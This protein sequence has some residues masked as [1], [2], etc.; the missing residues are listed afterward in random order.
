[1]AVNDWVG[2][3]FLWTG[4]DFL[5]EANRWPSHGSGAGLLDIEGFWKRDAYLRQALWSDK[6]MVHAAAWTTGDETR[7]G[8][9]RV[10]GR[11]PAV[12][13]WGWENDPRKNIP[14]E[15]YSNCDTVEVLLNGRSLG[16]KPI[17]DKLAPVIGWAVPNEAG[18]VEVVGR[19]AGAAAAR[20]QLRSVGKAEKILLKPDLVTLKDEARQVSTIEITIA[21]RDGR[22]VPEAADTITC[23]VTGA[24]K[25]V[26][27]GNAD[28]SDNSAPQGSSKKAYQGRA[29]A[30]VRSGTHA[31]KVTVKVSA[32]GLTPAE[33]TLT[34]AR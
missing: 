21:D 16:E 2:G 18:V 33:I 3:Q 34:V 7:I 30:I 23:E 31:G 8:D 26:A 32:P 28:L 11:T 24:G 9:Q 22:R 6:P 14:V 13:R 4:M 12:E 10:L 27:V 19:K 20:F 17:A 1:V 29:V 25:L 5:G 15:I